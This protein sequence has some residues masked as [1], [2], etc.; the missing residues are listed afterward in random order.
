MVTIMK[1]AV[2]ILY[3]LTVSCLTVFVMLLIYNEGLL[4][5]LEKGFQSSVTLLSSVISSSVS[6]ILPIISPSSNIA[7]SEVA[8][9]SPPVQNKQPTAPAV[10]ETYL[11]NTGI[12]GLK[13]YE[14]GKSLLNLQEQG[15]YNKIALSVLN[16]ESSVTIENGAEPVVMKKVLQYYLQDHVENFYYKQSKMQTYTTSVKNVNSYKYTFIFSYQYDSAVV[17][18]YRKEISTKAQQLLAAA[19]G[20]NTGAEKLRALHDALIRSCSYDLAAVNNPDGF[21][22]SYNIYGSIVN[23]KAV[24][25]GY[26]EAMK[27][28]LDT[29][30]VKSIEVTGVAGTSSG[31]SNHAWNIV[32]ISNK[33]YYTDATF[34]DPVTYGADGKPT[35]QNTIKEDYLQFTQT[36]E[37]KGTSRSLSPYNSQDPFVN[38]ENYELLPPLG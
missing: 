23:G 14:Y 35:G 18:K 5:K 19:N 32:N 2:K 10:S 12:E 38:S 20:K 37:P 26:A 4:F 33:W 11:A 13:V 3:V 6:D 28:L 24:C 16:M 25:E 30:G 17:A 27:L 8:P 9:P 22:D 21:F 7:V 15:F 36:T 34:D 29:A 1:K 31:S